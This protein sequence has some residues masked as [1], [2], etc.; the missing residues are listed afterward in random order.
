MSACDNLLSLRYA[1][2]VAVTVLILQCLTTAIYKVKTRSLIKTR[3]NVRFSKNLN[4]F[5]M[6]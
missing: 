2:C 3:I 4:S 5:Q 1:V 6:Q